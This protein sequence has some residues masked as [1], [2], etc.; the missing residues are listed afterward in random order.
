MEQQEKT[1][2][3]L[4]FKSVRNFAE[5]NSV[6]NERDF[7]GKILIDGCIDCKDSCFVVRSGVILCGGDKKLSK[8][9][10]AP[11]KS[12]HAI[13]M[14]NF[15]KID[16]LTIEISGKKIVSDYQLIKVTADKTAE[17]E[18][19]TC[20]LVAGWK[21]NPVQ[22]HFMAIKN[23]NGCLKLKGQLNFV[24]KVRTYSSILVLGDSVSGGRSKLEFC[25]NSEVKVRGKYAEIFSCL[26]IECQQNSK[27]LID[28]VAAT[29]IGFENC[30]LI[31]RENFELCVRGQLR[32]WKACD[33]ILNGNSEVRCF[34]KTKV[35]YNCDLE[36]LGN[37][38]LILNSLCDNGYLFDYTEICLNLCSKIE[39]VVLGAKVCYFHNC[40]PVDIDAVYAGLETSPTLINR[41]R[42]RF[43]NGYNGWE[44]FCK[45][46]EYLAEKLEEDK[47]S[48]FEIWNEHQKRRQALKKRIRLY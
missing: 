45:W 47:L 39:G 26:K 2:T 9:V 4:Q 29:E 5:L 6:L 34:G 28:K 33:V 24:S 16:N 30:E 14:Q 41:L 25:E 13:E 19:V 10:F 32:L 27:I 1:I 36:M 12:L 44:R 35:A 7:R 37:S 22:F 48:Q 23:L 20:Q 43:S 18:N 31:S 40:T 38:R 42:I 46:L 15:S 3:T 11:S 17:L 8:L 21:R